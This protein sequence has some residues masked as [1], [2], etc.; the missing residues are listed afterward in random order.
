VF[1]DDTPILGW[2]AYPIELNDI[3]KI[4]SNIVTRRR[5]YE[6]GVEAMTSDTDLAEDLQVGGTVNLC[7]SH[8]FSLVELVTNQAASMI[9]K[10]CMVLKNGWH[11]NSILFVH[12]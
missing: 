7:F 9:C 6:S 10:I 8:L 4:T 11:L 2:T 3:S 1:L 5:M 12:C